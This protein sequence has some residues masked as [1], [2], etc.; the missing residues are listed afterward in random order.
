MRYGSE[1]HG[2]LTEREELGPATAGL[3]GDNGI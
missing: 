3:R 1:A 2:C